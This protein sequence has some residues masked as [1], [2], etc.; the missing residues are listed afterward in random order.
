[1]DSTGRLNLAALT[2]YRSFSLFGRSA[3]VTAGLPYGVGTFKGTVAEAEIS[4][5]R[6]GLFDSVYRFS[7][8]LAGGRAMTLPE[9]RQWRQKTLVGASVKVIAPTGQYD[10]AKLINLG[11][12]RWAFKPE[13]GVSRRW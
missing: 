4:A 7:V 10:P 12:N 2:L 13:V 1:T 6:S 5:H 8:N 3:N 9:M 11:G